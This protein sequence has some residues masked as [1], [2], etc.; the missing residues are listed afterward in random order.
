[1]R[2]SRPLLLDTLF[3]DANLLRDLQQRAIALLKLNKAVK[4]LL[5]KAM[6]EHCRVANYRHSV[7]VLEVSNASWLTRLRYEQP[8]LLTALRHEILPSLASIDIKI[9]PSLS[10]K[11]QHP[12]APRSNLPE[13]KPEPVRRLSEQSAEQIRELAARS[14]GKLKEKLERLAALAERGASTASR[15][16]KP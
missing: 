8:A 12:A 6:H 14:K 1:M 10:T 11:I 9:N 7:L 13:N 5:P 2:D 15:D 4:A 3:D 16:E